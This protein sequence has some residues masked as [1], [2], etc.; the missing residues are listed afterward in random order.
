MELSFLE[1]VFLFYHILKINVL[2]TD[3]YNNN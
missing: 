2:E 3:G 1:N